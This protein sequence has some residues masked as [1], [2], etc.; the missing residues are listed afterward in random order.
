MD[1]IFQIVFIFQVF[2]TFIDHK[3]GRSFSLT[4]QILS[5][6]APKKVKVKKSYSR[7]REKEEKLRPIIQYYTGHKKDFFQLRHYQQ[8]SFRL[9]LQKDGAG[10]KIKEIRFRRHSTDTK[11]PFS[12]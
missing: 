6:F 3:S 9:P 2:D 1:E 4:V 10:A 7:I 5:Q 11:R 12:F 8:I